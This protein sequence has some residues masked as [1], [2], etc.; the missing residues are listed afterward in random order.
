MSDWHFKV[1]SVL[2]MEYQFCGYC[3]NACA[4]CIGEKVSDIK[5]SSHGNPWLQDFYGQRNECTIKDNSDEFCFCV[6]GEEES[7]RDKEQNVEKHFFIVVTKV[8]H[9][10]PEWYEVDGRGVKCWN[11][12]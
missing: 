9:V 12:G 1:S 5:N 6:H 7:H 3:T 4:G 11:D 8:V 2:M 10:I